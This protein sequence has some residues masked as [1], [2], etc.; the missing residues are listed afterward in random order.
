MAKASRMLLILFKDDAPHGAATGG[1]GG[2]RAS[3]GRAIPAGRAGTAGRHRIGGRRG[4]PCIVSAN[5]RP[6]RRP[7][8]C[9]ESRRSSLQP[10]PVDPLTINRLWPIPRLQYEVWTGLD[11]PP[12]AGILRSVLRCSI[13]FV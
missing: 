6:V 4:G 5:A 1:R 8:R 12:A 9:P 10:W 11:F 3:G 13:F 7:D 2:S